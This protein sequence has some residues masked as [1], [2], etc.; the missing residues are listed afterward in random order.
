MSHGADSEVTV[1]STAEPSDDDVG[2]QPGGDAPRS[3]RA[4]SLRRHSLFLVLL[5]LGLAL[6][7][8]TMLGFRWQLWFTDSYEYV[9]FTLHLR[10]YGVRPSGYSLFLRALLPVHD[11]GF[12]VA[13]QHLLGLACAVLPYTVAVRHRVRPWIAALAMAPVLFDAYEIQLEHLLLSDT[14]FMFLLVAAVALALWR[15]G[16]TALPPWWAMA[17]AGLCVGV[18]AVTRSVGLPLLVIFGVF[19]LIRWLTV[20]WTRRRMGLPRR[21][22]VRRFGGLVPIVAVAVAGVLPMGAYA[23]WYASVHGT[24]GFSGSSGVFLYG[25][26]MAFADCAK[27]RPPPALRPLCDPTPVAERP[28][29]QFYIWSARSPLRK[30][31]GWVF[32][33]VNDQRAGQFAKLAMRSQPLDYA[34]TV[35]DDT[36]HAFHWHRTVFPDL[37]TYEQYQFASTPAPAPQW[38]VPT[39]REYD[40]DWATTV[41][42]PYASAMRWYQQEI[43]LP[44]TLLGVFMV[45]A[46]AGVVVR[47]RRLGGA[48]LLPLTLAAALIVLPAMTADFSYRYL[49]PTLPLA[50]LALALALRRRRA[51]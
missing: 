19:L 15:T 35:A 49:M 41:V 29:S 31:G 33:P 26:T 30:L 20:V 32:G 22:M 4:A 13:L 28:S 27:M 45:V 46:A 2:P 1:V 18:A 16:P 37:E 44:G 21:S 40:P 24:Y 34:R 51:G 38:V 10:P 17:V 14:L 12:V 7:V 11:F 36:L 47:W 6:R 39:L 9:Y 48:A 5:T 8:V 3:A 43:Y 25:R 23:A 42:E 50:G